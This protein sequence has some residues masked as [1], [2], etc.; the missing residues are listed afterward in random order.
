MPELERVETP[1]RVDTPR[2]ETPRVE[3]P[4]IERASP[5][6]PTL[7]E[8]APPLPAELPEAGTAEW[9]ERVTK[10]QANLRATL[11]DLQTAPTIL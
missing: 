11:T 10:L 1:A 5:T 3:T 6:N 7:P 9:I 4:P 2:V 8:T